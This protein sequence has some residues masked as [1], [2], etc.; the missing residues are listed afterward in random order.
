MLSD[1]HWLR[2]L[3]LL[4][5][6]L[7]TLLCLLAWRF[8]REQSPWQQLLAPHL[9]PTLIA[10]EQQRS[11]R[12]P[13]IIAWLA[14][15]LL[16]I[17]A[18][19]PSITKLPQPA[20]QLQ[21]ATVLVL[22][23]SLSMLATDVKPDRVTQARF[24][25]LDFATQLGE[26]EL[27][28]LT[29]AGDAYVISPLTP[30][31]NNIKLLLPDLKP[32]I[33]P[34][35][36]SDVQSALTLA[37]Q[38]LNQA[39]YPKG[40]IILMTDGFSTTHFMQLRPML[41]NFPHR[42]SVLAVGTADGAPIKLSSGELLKDQQGSIVIPKVPFTQLKELASLTGGV[43][44]QN[45][46]DLAD[47]QS[48][49]ALTPL[50][51]ADQTSTD[52]KLTGDEW[53]DAGVYLCWLLLPLA[54]WLG[55]RSTIML[56]PVLLLLPP[57]TQAFEWQDL[58]KSRQQQAQQAYQQQDYQQAIEK[59]DQSIWQ[60]NAAYRA[61]D[62]AAAEQFYRQD[63]SANGLYNLG[64]SLIQQQKYQ[65]A[66]D[67]YQQ[68]ASKQPD[69]AGLAQNTELAEKLLNQQQEQEKQQAQDGQQQDGE[70]Q[71][72]DND[73]QS[74]DQKNGDNKDDPQNSDQQGS[75]AQN[76]D[77]NGDQ[78]NSNQQSSDQQNTDPKNNGQ[79]GDSKQ[80][81][82]QKKAEDSEK[83][84]AEKQQQLTEAE[85]QAKQAEGQEQ[86]KAITEAWPNATP[87]QSQQLDGLMRKVQDDP[88]L[89]LRNKM[90]QEYQKRQQQRLPKGAQEEW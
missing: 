19:G 82:E 64:N 79:Q 56:I 41:D 90:L 88:S 34:V 74:S 42:I 61:G 14:L 40:D 33:M 46:F 51:M 43:F 13:F 22:D 44:V 39:G 66:L 70:Q 6:P 75:D 28:L 81:S 59:F 11:Q 18:A 63:P 67:A 38:L 54:L 52:S 16:A 1:F 21:R 25:A 83:T 8:R 24:K 58:F 86:Q 26:G 36:G 76:Q 71:S 30:D 4:L 45:S 87:E 55:K 5:L 32:E 62:Y 47:V 3:W 48:L 73:S 78:Q 80:D 23:M 2:P 50:E 65:E 85:Q 69:I 60:G 53:Q 10:T 77:Q 27:A 57:P 89:L 29:F 20:F 12:K 31:H 9:Q 49:L 35:Q 17:A 7:V 37:A 15:L 72:K 84:A 68:A